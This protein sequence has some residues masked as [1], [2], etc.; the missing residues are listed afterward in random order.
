MVF[1]MRFFFGKG[2]QTLELE[3]RR[4]VIIDCDPGIDDALALMLAVRS[5]ELDILGITIVSGN[6]EAMQCYWNAKKVLALMDREDIPVHL[7]SRAPLYT[8]LETAEDTH[9]DDGLGG[10]GATLAYKPPVDTTAVDFIL[11]TLEREEAGT[12]SIIAIGPLTNVA[13]ARKQ[14]PETLARVQE[15]VSMGGAFRCSGNVSPVAEFNYWVDP[16]A[17]RDVLTGLKCPLTMVGLDVTWPVV[18]TPLHAGLLSQFDDPL[19]DFIVG[20]MRFY[21]DFHWKEQHILGS[22]INDPVAVAYFIDRSLC[23]GTDYP[24]TVVTGGEARG[25]SLVD[26]RYYPEKRPNCRVL[27]QVD[28]DGVLAF[29]LTRLFPEWEEDI[30]ECIKINGKRG[31]WTHE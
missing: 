8:P 12:V 13:A 10:L 24:V 27:T 26:A 1:S 14:A 15:M 7:G 6:I 9:G 3:A 30:T 20:M 31:A 29:V 23:C 22:V 5:P 4:K 25:M 17:A 11:E 2:R 16:D 18:F 28:A 19:A 21:T